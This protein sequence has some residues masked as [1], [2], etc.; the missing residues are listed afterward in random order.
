MSSS[1]AV[2][3]IA[4]VGAGLM[5]HGIAQEFASKGIDVYLQSRSQHTLDTALANIDDNIRRLRTLSALDATAAAALDSHLHTTTDIGEAVAGA[6]VVIETV[7]EDL[8]I[9]REVFSRI[10][11]AAPE[12]AI[13]ASNTS[14]LMPSSFADATR[15]PD[16]VL[17]A[18]YANPP[19]LIPLVEIV[20]ST[21]T[22]PAAVEI[23][24]RLL[25]RIGK[26]PILI[27]KEAPGFVAN[28]LQMALLREALEIIHLGIAD[29]EDV[30]A[31]LKSSIGRRWAVAG[32]FEV[33]ELAGLDLVKSIADGLFPHLAAGGHSP[34]LDKK[35]AA[36]E[37]GAKSGGGFREWT[38]ARADQV[39]ARIAQAL[40]NIDNWHKES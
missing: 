6:D 33:L 13:L 11:A 7:C 19:Y 36:G 8:Q 16:K 39:R 21:A 34:L 12:H 2:Q 30:D 17:V 18:H 28:R 1:E 27:R 20:P 23:I 3:S 31:V 40:V 22:S 32:V 26:T 9:K 15:R 4:V 24:F 35:V 14:A 25:E 10:D 37:L 38:P 5:G 29:A